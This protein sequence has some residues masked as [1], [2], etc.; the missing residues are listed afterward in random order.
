MTAT[1]SR[2]VQRYLPAQRFVHWMGATGF[3]LLLA[4]GSIL[5]WSP[6]ASLATGG[7]SR[8]LHRIGAILYALWPIL[9]AILNPA[10]LRETVK[11]SLTFTRDDFAWFKHVVR[12]FFGDARN[13]PPQGRVNPGQKLHHLG[14][15]VVSFLIAGSGL[16]LWLGTGRLGAAN[17]AL[18]A[19]VHDLSMLA[20]TVLLVGHLYFTF[21]YGALDGMLKG[22]VTEAY[23]AMEHPKWLATLPESAFI[24]D[25]HKPASLAAAN[26]DPPTSKPDVAIEP[27][28]EAHP[29]A[30]QAAPNSLGDG[31]SAFNDLGNKPSQ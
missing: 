17:L 19:T 12:Y 31:D 5:L 29:S 15:G 26:A 10:G 28:A 21:V 4:T 13:L 1:P 22:H 2:N 24:T 23:A 9:Y 11:D 14:I 18:A 27:F 3:I 6:L 7:T 20:L 30:D 25:P 8:L 16:V